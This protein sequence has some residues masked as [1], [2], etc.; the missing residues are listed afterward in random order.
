M[1]TDKP[2]LVIYTDP[3]IIEKLDFI[4]KKQFRSRANMG[5]SILRKYIEQYE[6]ENGEIPTGGGKS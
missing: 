6:A 5:D 3:K 4:A 2:R 1:S